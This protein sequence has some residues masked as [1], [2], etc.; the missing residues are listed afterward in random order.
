MDTAGGGWNLALNLDTSDGHVMWWAND[1]WT[2]GATYGTPTLSSG[3]HLSPVWNQYSASELLLVVHESGILKGWKRF[4]LSASETMHT[5]MHSESNHYIS[6]QVLSSSISGVD[7]RECLVRQS[8]DLIFNRV[9]SSNDFDRISSTY[10]DP[11]SSN[12]G[13]G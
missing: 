13:G 1:L 9:H 4:G 3:D 2:S 12:V 8:S 11:E 10:C 7:S 5:A 6:S